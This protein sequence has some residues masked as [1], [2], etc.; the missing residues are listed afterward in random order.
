MCGLLSKAQDCKTNPFDTMAGNNQDPRIAV[1]IKN[2]K[3]P[4]TSKRPC[5]RNFTEFATPLER[6][7]L[8]KPKTEW[9]PTIGDFLAA[10]GDT[11]TIMS[12]ICQLTNDIHPILRDE[13]L[14]VCPEVINPSQ[15][16]ED[17]FA[18][19][20]SPHFTDKANLK[21]LVK[22]RQPA[23][24]LPKHNP[25]MRT[26][27][28]L[29]SRITEDEGT[30]PF[31]AGIID[32]V[33]GEGEDAKI[34][35][36][37]HPRRRL[38]KDRKERVLRY[39]QEEFPKKVRFH[40]KVFRDEF[41]GVDE[42]TSAITSTQPITELD[43]LRAICDKNNEQ[44]C[45]GCRDG[46]RTYDEKATF[47]HLQLNIAQW[48]CL[49]PLE[50][51]RTMTIS[52]IQIEMFHHA[53]TICHELAHALEMNIID[54]ERFNMPP[55]NDEVAIEIGFALEQSLYG[56]VPVPERACPFDGDIYLL[57]WPCDGMCD[58]YSR[59]DGQAIEL[60]GTNDPGP[61]RY[62]AVEPRKVQAFFLQSFWDDPNPPVGCWKKM[63]L[64]PCVE[65]AL[66][67]VDFDYFT[68]G[69]TPP[70]LPELKRVRPN[71]MTK[72]RVRKINKSGR[73]LTQS[74]YRLFR[75]RDYEEKRKAE[76][77]EQEKERLDELWAETM[78][79]V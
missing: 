1:A 56:A 20:M 77:Y 59:G 36:K 66:D 47:P 5:K 48:S 64:R 10:G 61:D 54:P 40:F 28:Q 49:Q 6:E 60:V 68:T 52:Q 26:I 57:Q 53:S 79:G 45:Y 58:T 12:Y 65:L 42:D 4:I 71:T 37:V 43:P 73:K 72:E 16:W 30:L 19:C 69:D 18:Y 24:I 67:P 75:N 70:L 41:G 55:L 35:F 14:C 22:E 39:L 33:T 23:S 50:T 9:A 3:S 74:R 63:W 2:R 62:M 27:L 8:P 13:N 17:E 31:W 34:S 25:V 76:F 29:A 21:G 46:K 7:Y 44:R 78:K 15:F 38:S 51:L 11:T 32:A